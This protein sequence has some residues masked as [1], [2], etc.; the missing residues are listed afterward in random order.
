MG[1]SE[2]VNFFETD[3][4]TQVIGFLKIGIGFARETDDDV[5]TKC[6]PSPNPSLDR[7]GGDFFK[8]IKSFNN[9]FFCIWAVHEIEDFV[10]SGLEGNV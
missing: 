10:G 6:K 1:E 4:L 3:L 9:F 2:N 5:G 8:F 7:A